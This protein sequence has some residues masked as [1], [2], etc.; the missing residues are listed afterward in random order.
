MIPPFAV[1]LSCLNILIPPNIQTIPEMLIALVLFLLAMFFL[2]PDL[3][4]AGEHLGHE[5]K[6][7]KSTAK[8]TNRWAG[9]TAHLKSLA[10]AKKLQLIKDLTARRE[11]LN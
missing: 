10:W 6:R 11:R 4:L 1:S 5:A 7:E 2:H 3:L 8:L 9:E